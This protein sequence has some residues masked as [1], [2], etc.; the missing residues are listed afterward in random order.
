[1]RPSL[2]TFVGFVLALAAS[3]G[4]ASVVAAC[5]ARVVD[6][7]AN[8]AS[9]PSTQPQSVEDAGLT[10]SQYG[11]VSLDDQELTALRV[12]TCGGHCT[13]TPADP[14]DL[15]SKQSVVAAMAGQWT[16]CE[17]SFGPADAVG[18]ELAP[19]CR[20][21]LLRKD[22]DGYVVRGTEARYQATYDIYDPRPAG[23]PRRID[24]HLDDK[25][26][27]T[28]DVVAY[29]CPEHLRLLA[30]G[31]RIELA[32]DFGDAGRPNP[33]AM[34]TRRVCRML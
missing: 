20:V 31:K 32:P 21:F 2:H 22:Q 8:D 14:Y 12:G 6:V 16:F 27:L 17:G 18:V 26:T 25:T 23:T 24:I 3:A 7:G 5:D 9:A 28:F 15:D 29:R 11:C 30:P 1:L 19:G 33:V 34:T 10:R 13:S 4:A